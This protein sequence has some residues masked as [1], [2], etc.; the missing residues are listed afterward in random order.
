MDATIECV[1]RYPMGL[2]FFAAEPY[3]L[4]AKNLGAISAHNSLF[5]AGMGM[6]IMELYYFP[7]SCWLWL[8]QHFQHILMTNSARLL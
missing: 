8:N 6:G 5:S 3:V 7:Y 2:G 1:E 4:Y